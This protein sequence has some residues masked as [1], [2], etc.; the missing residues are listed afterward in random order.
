MTYGD[1]MATVRERGAYAA[2]EAE[3]IVDAVIATLGERLPPASAGHLADQ[4]PTPLAD[5]I[6]DSGAAA[7][8]WGVSEFVVQVAE[9]TEQDEESAEQDTRVVFSVLADQISGGE[10]NKLISQLPSGYADLFG[11]AELS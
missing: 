9:E 5:L 2:D 3:R 4:L 11:H 6:D 7:R 8:T 10:M 1:F